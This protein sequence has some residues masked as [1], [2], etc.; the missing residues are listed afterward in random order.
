MLRGWR[1][2]IIN[3]IVA[4]LRWRL[5]IEEYHAKFVEIEQQ[6]A[7]LT[8]SVSTWAVTSWIEQATLERTPLVSVILPTHNRSRLLRRAAASVVAQNYSNWEILIIDDGSSDDTPAVIDQLTNELGD[9]RVRAM[10]IDPSGVC[11]A[12]N[13][14]LKAARGEFICYLDDD[15]TLHPLWLKAVVWAF[16]QRPQVDVVYGGIVIDDT[17]RI[18]R[19]SRG[20]LPFYY[21]YSFDRRQLVSSNLADIGV[22]A[23]RSGMAEAHFDESLR[24]MGDWDLLLRLTREKGPLVLPVLACF[25]STEEPDRLSGGITYEVDAARVRKKAER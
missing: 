6:L 13:H 9:Q 5:G 21:L 11:A 17:L 20:A 12:R 19:K 23:H 14:G 22:I 2:T 18:N 16:S 10:R 8:P 7:A 15:N 3:R 24:E 25:Y 4:S 1:E